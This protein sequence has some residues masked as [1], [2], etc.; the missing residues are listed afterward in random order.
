[1][2]RGRRLLSVLAENRQIAGQGDFSVFMVGVQTVVYLAVLVCVAL[3]IYRLHGAGKE[4]VLELLI[5]TAG[6]LSRVIMGFSPTIYASGDRTALFCSIAVLILILRNLSIWLRGNPEVR[7]KAVMG[8][9]VG[10]MI[11]CNFKRA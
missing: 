11:L 4:T 10:V 7:Y 9:Y 6:F 1:M 8:V 2:P 3:T 5:L